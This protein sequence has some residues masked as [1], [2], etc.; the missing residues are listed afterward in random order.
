MEYTMSE[1]KLKENKS[2]IYQIL[3]RWQALSSEYKI[4]CLVSLISVSVVGAASLRIT[5]SSAV[6]D[7]DS[8][9][10][11]LDTFIPKGFVLVPIDVQ[12]YEALDSILG[13]Y[14]L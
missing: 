14:G 6:S 7:I 10:A 1:I 8:S 13:K 3:D 5:N 12:N 2:L 9:I 11:G 4:L